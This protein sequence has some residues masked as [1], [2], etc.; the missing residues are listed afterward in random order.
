MHEI[1]AEIWPVNPR[2]EA[3]VGNTTAEGSAIGVGIDFIVD[4]GD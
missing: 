2:V 4:A 1:G 3:R